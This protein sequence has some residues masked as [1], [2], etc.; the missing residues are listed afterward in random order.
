[1]QGQGR[2][3]KTEII[4]MAIKHIKHLRSL[5]PENAR[6]QLMDVTAE[7]GQGAC[8]GVVVKR[9]VPGSDAVKSEGACTSCTEKFYIG[10]K[11]GTNEVRTNLHLQKFFLV[12]PFHL[13][14]Q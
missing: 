14:L 10:Y 13:K 12:Y 4:E 8:G 7:K 2:I 5:I 9:E 6:P 11:E 1:M 3:E